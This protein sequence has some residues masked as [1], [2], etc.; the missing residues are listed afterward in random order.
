MRLVYMGTP[1]FAVPALQALAGN[2]HDIV[3]VYTQ[4][5]R[6]ARRGK[7]LQRTAVHDA[8]EAL[9]LTVRHPETL[10][11][12]DV[13]EEFGALGADAAVVA[14]YGLILPP[15]VLSAP[16]LGC[17]N[18]HASLLPRWRGAAPVQR[19]ILAGDRV[20]GVTIMQMEA[21]LDTGPMLLTRQVEIVGKTAGLLTD[22]LA[23]V[24]A[25]LIVETLAGTLPTSE[26]QPDEGV[27]YAKKIEKIEAA[28]DFTKPAVDVDRQV[29]AFNPAPGAWFEA[30][31]ERIKCLEVAVEAGSAA[32][33][34]VLDG[35]RAIAC[36]EGSVRL[37][38]LQRPGKRPMSVEDILNGFDMPESVPPC[39]VSS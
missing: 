33:G 25:E 24:G 11:P 35:G 5:P 23:L 22:E 6:A 26:P 8:A 30:A 29:R 20:T 34:T 15:P 28:L 31:G 14:A 3:A 32:P 2:G 21:G 13:Q 39:P 19:A 10:K 12:A 7:K 9:G 4:P 1:P 27:T 36:G 38:L 37:R 17:L 18:I 16:R